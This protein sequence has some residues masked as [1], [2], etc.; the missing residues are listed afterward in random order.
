[1]QDQISCSF[2]L[3]FISHSFIHSFIHPSIRSFSPS[4][5]HLF[6]CTKD[7]AKSKHTKQ[8]PFNQSDIRAIKAV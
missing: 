7:V 8:C 6:I 3:L 5:N 1:M 4:C 2:D